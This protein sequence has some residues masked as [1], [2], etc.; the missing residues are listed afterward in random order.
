M[1]FVPSPC[2]GRYAVR[3]LQPCYGIKICVA[4]G[5][6]EAFRHLLLI[7]DLSLPLMFS[8]RTR[9]ESTGEPPNGAGAVIK[10]LAQTFS[11]DAVNITME[12]SKCHRN[13]LPCKMLVL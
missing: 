6:P 8:R 1:F 7:R 10:L 13:S 2:Y 11:R 12:V 9:T 5:K 3:D 4:A